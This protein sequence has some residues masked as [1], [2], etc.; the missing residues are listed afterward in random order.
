M[1]QTIKHSPDEISITDFVKKIRSV[2][3]YLKSKWLIILITSIA[4]GG[5]GLAYAI[6]K[7]TVYTASSTFVLDD[8]NKSGGLN[9]YAS[10]ASMAGIDIGGGSAGGIFQNDNILELYRSRLM[11]EKTLLSEATFNGKKQ[12]L[13]ERYIDFNHLRDVWKQEDNNGDISFT[14]SSDNFS[15]KQDSII[16]KLVEVLNKQSLTVS[17]PDKKLS[18]IRVDVTNKDELFAKEFNLKLV[19]NVNDFYKT[20]RTKKSNQNIQ[21]LQFQADSVK[22]VLNNSINGV[23]SAI[24]A[25][26]NAN[27]SLQI[28]RAPSQRK[29]IDVQASTAIYGEIV[30]NLELSK[31]SLRQETPL[32]QLI[33]SPILPLEKTKLNKLVGFFVGML[34]ASLSIV[35]ILLLFRQSKLVPKA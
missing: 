11:I 25:S 14:G 26:P 8:G 33:D 18:I 6:L 7:K 15:R 23:A 32:I 17:K 24:D 1:T 13:I 19:A 12:Q 34:L 35:L 22:R 28:L 9:Q 3:S 27:P 4:G 2:S 29:Q 5:L 21:T 20:T 31:M 30:K 10:L 16:S